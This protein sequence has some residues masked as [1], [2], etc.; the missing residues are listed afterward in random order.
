VVR[1]CPTTLATPSSTAGRRAVHS[2]ICHGWQVFKLMAVS[3]GVG[4]V[5]SQI[6]SPGHV[7]T[8]RD[9]FLARVATIRWLPMGRMDAA[10][11][12]SPGVSAVT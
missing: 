1:P 3:D 12:T 8:L 2:F 6:M 4:L 10:P 5:V 9:G 7:E 11:M